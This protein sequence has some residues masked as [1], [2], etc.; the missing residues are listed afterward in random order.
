M[1]EIRQPCCRHRHWLK[2]GRRRITLRQFSRNDAYG[3]LW[4]VLPKNKSSDK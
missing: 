1:H 4:C 3:K 2:F